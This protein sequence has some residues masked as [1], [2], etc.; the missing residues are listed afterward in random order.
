MT[1]FTEAF[2]KKYEDSKQ[3]IF[4]RKFELGGHTFKVRVPYVHEA[5]AIYKK[6][7]EPDQELI[8]K[9]YREITDPLML[10]KDNPDNDSAFVFTENDVLVSGK[11]LRETAKTKVQT[12]TKITEFFKLLI[13]E[14]EGHSFDDLTY[15]EIE[16][17]FPMSVQAQI[18]EKI[19]EAISPTYKETRGN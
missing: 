10:F 1:R 6:I 18:I 11:S 15:A 16:A 4:T 9:T 3:K 12:E 7:Q 19:S 5:D 8:E 2:G 14:L 17:E 13:P